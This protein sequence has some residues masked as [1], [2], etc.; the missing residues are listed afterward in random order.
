MLLFLLVAAALYLTAILLMALAQ[1]SLLFP[2]RLMSGA[3]IPLPASG[4]RLQVKAADGTE[5]H[6]LHIPGASPGRGVLLGFGGNAW[7][8]V[9]L[10]N[11]LSELSP[12]RDVVVF[13]YRGY[14][15]SGGLPS[16]AS[17]FA[18]ALLVRDSLGEGVSDL[19]VI[20]VGLSIGA[21]P[22]MH[23]ARHRS[24][25]GA[26]LVTPFDSLAN[27]AS[28]H[29]WWAPVRLLLRHRMEIADDAAKVEEPVAIITAEHD[30]IV[31]AALAEALRSKVGNLVLYRVIPGADHNDLYD[32]PEFIAAFREAVALIGAGARRP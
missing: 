11:F 13:H 25:A 18:D 12:D 1:T 4:R 17:L 23:L 19:P 14:P 8:A 5:L 28:H 21:G 10:A 31:P 2:T 27:L 20:A 32:R 29:Y 30:S 24:L 6:G 22:A 26:I 15:P 3:E 9:H 7:N 16:A